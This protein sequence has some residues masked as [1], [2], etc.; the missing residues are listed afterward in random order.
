MIGPLFSQSAWNNVTF[1]G[2]E[3]KEPERVL[4]RA[5]ILGT[6][7][8]VILYFLANVAYVVYAQVH[9]HSARPQ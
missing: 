9:R 3:I 2:G 1:T 7:S 4:P 6:A 8:V 5:M